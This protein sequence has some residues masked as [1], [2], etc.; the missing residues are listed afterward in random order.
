M[1]TEPL[2]EWAGISLS[3]PIVS[4]RTEPRHTEDDYYYD[5]PYDDDDNDTNDLLH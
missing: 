4:N 3:G 1:V 2:F 5:P